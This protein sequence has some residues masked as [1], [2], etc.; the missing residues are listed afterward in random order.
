MQ[1]GLVT[2]LVVLATGVLLSTASVKLAWVR[3]AQVSFTS[4]NVYK[5]T[6]PESGN[7]NVF[8]LITL[9][10]ETAIALADA[11]CNNPA[12]TTH[13]GL[14]EAH[15]RDHA[16]LEAK[17]IVEEK[18]HMI[19]NRPRVL[20]G[21]V[22]EV[23]QSYT[24]VSTTP[25][26]SSYWISRVNLPEFTQKHL[27]RFRI[28]LV[29]KQNSQSSYLMPMQYLQQHNINITAL[30]IRLHSN[31]YSLLQ[32]FINNELDII[33]SW[34][35]NLQNS[36]DAPLTYLPIRKHMATGAWFLLNDVMQQDDLSCEL[37]LSTEVLRQYYFHASALEKADFTCV[38]LATE[39]YE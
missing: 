38:H 6:A 10:P 8:R 17:E 20:L 13:Y 14:I 15:W 26:Y 33:A 34:D 9:S 4:L 23:E 2:V 22:P 12:I 39:R 3:L 31:H 5:C 32:A 28:G 30:D 27:S 24:N 37:L 36:I 7:T 25:S 18:F 1:I 21:L 35:T 16:M 11:I 19:W 29:N